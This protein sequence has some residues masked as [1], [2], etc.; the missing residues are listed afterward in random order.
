MQK[1]FPRNKT[2]K[3]NKKDWQREKSEKSGAFLYGKNSI[4]ERV[5]TNPKSIK[6]VYYQSNFK[7][8]GLLDRLEK[9]GICAEVATESQLARLKR[10]DRLQ[11]VV[12]H[13]E[14]FQY[15]PMDTLIE[16]ALREKRTVLCL[17][18]INDP[19][20]LGSILR[21]TA[22]FGNF[23]IVIP[24]YSACDV[25]DTVMHVASGGENYVPVCMVNNLSHFLVDAKDAGFTV[26][27]SIVEEGEDLTTVTLPFPLCVIL[28]SEGK[29]VRH[30]LKQ[31]CDLSVRIPMH[32]A[33]LSFNVAVAAAIFCHEITKQRGMFEE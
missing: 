2:R 3:Q 9:Q 14:A 8:K 18:E 12:A 22:C 31:Y 28:G 16:D 20:N 30:G 27:G 24:R 1:D 15:T 29:G 4:L 21:I 6:K 11:G 19:H 17:D 5:R 13:V 10:A 32:G 23:S 33:H 26:A 7:E 25:N